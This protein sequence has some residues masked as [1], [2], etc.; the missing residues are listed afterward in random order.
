MKS[1]SLARITAAAAFLLA[2]G[3]FAAS[4]SND[5]GPA[6]VAYDDYI[7]RP[8][9]QMRTR[10]RIKL[11]QTGDVRALKILSDSY[12]KAEDPK[13][14]VKYLLTS[15][16]SQ[17]LREE[18]FVPIYKEWREK[19]T[20]PGDAWLWYRSLLIHADNA[21]ND[22]LVATVKSTRGLFIRAAAMEAL[23]ECSAEQCLPLLLELL[24]AWKQNIKEFKGID[25]T[26]MLECAIR[27]MYARA[28]ELGTDNFRNVG[29]QLI[30]WMADK[31]TDP[32]TRL[33]MARYLREMLGGEKLFVNG[34]PWL[35]KLLNPTREEPRDSR[36]VSV[37]PTKFV[38]VEAT[39]VR[40]AYV[41]DLSDS[42]MKPMSVKEKE[43]IK[44]P[45]PP[46]GPVTPGRGEKADKPAPEEPKEEPK[47][48]EDINDKLPWD[49]IKC[50]FH[51]AREYLKLSLQ[52]LR[53]EQF[54]CVI[55]VGTTA[56]LAKSTTGLVPA[57]PAN[58]QA[59][60][61]ELDNITPG[62]ATDVRKD[63]V[64]MGDTNLHGGIHRA[65]KVKKGGMVKEY[66]YVDPSTFPE[67]A[68]TVFV[69]SDGD[70]TDDDWA[71]PDKRDKDDQTGDPETRTK[72]PDQDVLRFPGPYGYRYE[73]TYLPDD[74]RR[75]NLFR[76][77]EIHCIGIGEAS[78]GL[79]QN[80]A[81]WGM[82]QVKMVGSGSGK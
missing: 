18:S 72:M 36:Y 39:G 45:P 54:Y 28:H 10:G 49:K 79:L 32:R 52:S 48:E 17:Y 76:K 69:L 59:T 27:M 65:F 51:A 56:E 4:Q 82:G 75:L 7:K 37:P 1:S 78:Y 68:D 22:E 12:G 2:L 44:K 67:G 3:S 19:Y 33:V 24:P 13:D 41:I 77:C 42:M 43:E 61:R 35:D 11:A 6:K 30:P 58:I 20:T 5:F 34:E 55:M 66:E 38:G 25:R 46:K 53:P 29:L 9:L 80:I 60:I 71:I 70:P 47:K 73:G 21:G 23:A 15:I 16:C 62:P 50:R 8:S 63:G 81:K 26:V 40:I 14:H 57:T 74:V 64:L 31:E